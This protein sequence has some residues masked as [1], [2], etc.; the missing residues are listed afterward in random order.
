MIHAFERA[1]LIIIRYCK[2]GSL[3]KAIFNKYYGVS[4][5]HP[6]PHVREKISFGLY[7]N[8]IPYPKMYNHSHML[9]ENLLAPLQVATTEN[10]NPRSS[11]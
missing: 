7:L 6:K 3:T 10:Q 9:N 5:R 2:H 1:S 11:H 4:S 8:I